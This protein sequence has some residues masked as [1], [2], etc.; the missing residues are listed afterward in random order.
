MLTKVDSLASLVC[1]LVCLLSG[2]A[3]Q[4]VEV[5]PLGGVTA[6][7]VWQDLQSRQTVSFS[8]VRDTA[9]FL[10]F[11]LTWLTAGLLLWRGPATRDHIR[12][13][14]EEEEE[15]VTLLQD[16][17]SSQTVD[18]SRLNNF[19]MNP[20]KLFKREVLKKPINSVVY[21]VEQS[22]EESV[23]LHLPGW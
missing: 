9:Q 10:L 20:V 19:F 2:S 1:L 16:R 5:S 21:I 18:I 7:E 11:N 23:C 4:T 6:Q 3:G 22:G 17:F 14:E 8:V 15:V 13:G 12:T